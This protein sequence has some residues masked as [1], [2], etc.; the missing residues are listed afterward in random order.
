MQAYLVVNFNFK[1]YRA[2][3]GDDS[4]LDPPVG[5]SNT[6]TDLT[7]NSSAPTPDPLANTGARR[8]TATRQIPLHGDDLND[9]LEG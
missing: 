9:L 6:A 8:R 4:S 1:L 5:G 7:T 3:Q 2:G